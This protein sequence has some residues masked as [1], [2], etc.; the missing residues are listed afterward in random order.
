MSII[1]STYINIK[2]G[3]IYVYNLID[4]TALA[5]SH[6]FMTFTMRLP[7]TGESLFTISPVVISLRD[8]Q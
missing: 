1:S 8:V 4:K 6:A 5:T 2:V 3:R 7:D